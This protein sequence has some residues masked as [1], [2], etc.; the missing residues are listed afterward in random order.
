[1]RAISVEDLQVWQQTRVFVAA[2]FATTRRFQSSLWIGDQLNEAA[3]SVLANI[4]E[5]FRQSSDR[6]FARYLT[7]AA[8]SAEEARTHLIA[9]SM[10]QQITAERLSEL[11]SDLDSILRM[12]NSF[13]HYLH[14]CDRKRRH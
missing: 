13:I 6:A 12:L 7:I 3:E 2:V 10:Q 1:M 4:A 5:G 14:R 8:G 11:T 9:A